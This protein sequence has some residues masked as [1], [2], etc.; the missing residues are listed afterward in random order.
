MLNMQQKTEM[1]IDLQKAHDTAIEIVET[2][3]KDGAKIPLTIIIATIDARDGKVKI[4]P[5]ILDKPEEFEHRNDIAE[6]IGLRAAKMLKEG[7]ITKVI[8]AHTMCE[9]YLSKTKIPP[10]KKPVNTKNLK[11][12]MNSMPETIR[13]SE[14][15]NAEDTAVITS[16]DNEGRTI[17]TIF[18][19]EEPEAYGTERKLTNKETIEGGEATILKAFWNVFNRMTN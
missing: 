9:A 18:N 13:P 11:E 10:N 4:L 17:N 5:E 16:M 12:I 15:P 7:Q 3:M 6:M 1:P 2:A 19:V 14:D 8:H